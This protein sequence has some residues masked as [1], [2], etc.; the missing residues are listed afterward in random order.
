MR[1]DKLRPALSGFLSQGVFGQV[2]SLDDLAQVF[3]EF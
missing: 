3:S 2:V 1:H